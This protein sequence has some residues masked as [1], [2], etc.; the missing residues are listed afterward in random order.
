M[1]TT[2]I[3][4]FAK[5][6]N[7]SLTELEIYNTIETLTSGFNLEKLE[8]LKDDINSYVDLEKEILCGEFGIKEIEAE[9]DKLTKQNKKI[10]VKEIKGNSFV[11]V[12]ALFFP[13]EFVC[14]RNTI[15]LIDKLLL[16]SNSPVSEKPVIEI[17]PIN[18]HPKIFKNEASFLFF[19]ELKKT[20]INPKNINAGVRLQTNLD[21]CLESVFC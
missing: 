7:C 6:R 10:P 21:F 4:F 1:E 8:M 2:L 14:F 9:V 20:T 17:K 11:N 15:K 3:D 13:L 5:I 19:E 18:F 16:K 12:E